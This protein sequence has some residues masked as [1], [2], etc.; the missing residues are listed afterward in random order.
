MTRRTRDPDQEHGG[1]EP[2]LESPVG[3][4][5]VLPLRD[6][7]EGEESLAACAKGVE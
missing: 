2:I 5:T 1:L 7:A 6:G 3:V 4:E